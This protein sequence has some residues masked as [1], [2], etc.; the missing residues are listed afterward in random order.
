M[1]LIN[2]QT[3]IP[4]E[5]I[6]IDEYML[7]SAEAGVIGETLRF[8]ESDEYFV[9]IGRA[10]KVEIECFKEKCER[11]NVKM[12]RRFSGG[13][14]VLQGPGCLNYSLILSY[15]RDCKLKEVN[16]SYVF[17]L[18]SILKSFGEQKISVQYLPISDMVF[19]NK[20]F[21]GNA[22]ARKKKYFLHHGTI[23]YDFDL[24]K[25]T[26]YIQY[27]PKE[28]EYRA[29]REHEAFIVNLS[30]DR[31]KAE[32]VIKNAFLTESS[33]YEFTEKDRQETIRLIERKYSKDFWNFTF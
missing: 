15:K 29:S 2:Y 32:T 7:M 31:K 8:W 11:D 5:N 27:P 10:G 33:A 9:V 23:L 14:T 13:G 24:C 20:K 6:A 21:S 17:V 28:P 25:I 18:D 12:I 16:S 1:K 22:Q 19:E 4:E 26:E 30:V 3:N